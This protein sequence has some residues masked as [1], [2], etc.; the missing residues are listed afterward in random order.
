MFS[1]LGLSLDVVG[2]V[3]LALG[4]F[5]Q[6]VPSAYGGNVRGPEDVAHDAGFACVGAPLLFVGFVCQSLQYFG[7]P[8]SHS[9]TVRVIVGLVSLAG[10]TVFAWVAY[11]LI[12]HYVYGLETRLLESAVGAGSVWK[13]RATL[14]GR[15]R[16]RRRSWL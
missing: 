9:T 1:V 5:G 11:G 14:M 8:G 13:R 15:L 10:A 12:Y 3:A 16:F 4:L 7:F 6:S 2:A